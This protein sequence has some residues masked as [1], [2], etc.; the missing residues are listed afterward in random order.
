[1]EYGDLVKVDEVITFLQDHLGSTSKIVDSAGNAMRIR[2]GVWGE[3]RDAISNLP[4]SRLYTGQEK[5][6]TGLYYYNGAVRKVS[7]SPSLF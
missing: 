2:Y 4:T 3:A 1:M 6:N 5:S 7:G